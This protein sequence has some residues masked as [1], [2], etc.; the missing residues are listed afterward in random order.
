MFFNETI[1]LSGRRNQ[2]SPPSTPAATSIVT[3]G[4]RQRDGPPVWREER[5]ERGKKKKKKQYVSL[6]F[7]RSTFA[8]SE[9]VQPQARGAKEEVQ[10]LSWANLGKDHHELL[11]LLEAL[12]VIPLSLRTTVLSSSLFLQISPGCPAQG[13]RG[14]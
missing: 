7:P 4:Q 9:A 13:A 1:A 14:T 3:I 2:R 6:T 12:V 10:A 8:L 5:N 11:S